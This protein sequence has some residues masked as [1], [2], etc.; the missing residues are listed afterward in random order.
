MV[1]LQVEHFQQRS[2][3]VAAEILP[4]L[5]DLI[6]HEERVDRPGAAHGLQDASR[7][8]ADI[9]APVAADLGLITHPA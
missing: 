4:E 2:R 7:Q 5:V 3:G 9:S 1:L 8:R 6:E